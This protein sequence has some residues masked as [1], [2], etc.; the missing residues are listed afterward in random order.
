[1]VGC[2]DRLKKLGN[3][4]R[5]ARTEFS[6]F[7]IENEGIVPKRT[8]GRA[9]GKRIGKKQRDILIRT[10]KKQ[11]AKIDYDAGRHEIT[12]GDKRSA[13]AH[14]KNA[15]KLTGHRDARECILVLKK[16]GAR[17]VDTII[18]KIMVN[19]DKRS[20]DEARRIIA[21]SKETPYESEFSPFG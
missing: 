15:V 8:F 20:P 16:F 12:L 5:R 11:A 4:D 21:E 2:A 17:G 9:I 18:E 19:V 14:F 6:R 13:L 3:G 1:M 7:V 10:A